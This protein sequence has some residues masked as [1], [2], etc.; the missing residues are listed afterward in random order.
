MAPN[1][2]IMTV[3]TAILVGMAVA[4]AVTQKSLDLLDQAVQGSL[5]GELAIGQRDQQRRDIPK[6]R[7]DAG[8]V[9]FIKAFVAGQQFGFHGQCVFEPSEPFLSGHNVYRPHRR[10][11]KRRRIAGS[12]YTIPTPA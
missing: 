10:I 1:E 5:G 2:I 7:A 9:V 8:M 3:S 11:I 12:H 4:G 6:L